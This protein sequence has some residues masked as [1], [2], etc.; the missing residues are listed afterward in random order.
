MST[1]RVV[2][3]QVFERFYTQV[4]AYCLRRSLTDADAED[5]TAE[6]F[7][8]ALRRRDIAPAPDV[9]LPWLYGRIIVGTSSGEVISV[10]GT[11][12]S[13]GGSTP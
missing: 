6:A 7:A 9:A 1:D 2:F 10:T 4:M 5:A 12:P 3:E 8:I 11:G 13:G